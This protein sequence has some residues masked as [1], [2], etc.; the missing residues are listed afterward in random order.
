MRLASILLFTLMPLAALA[1]ERAALVIGMGDYENANDLDGPRAD[2]KAVGAALEEL[3]FDVTTLIDTPG[4]DLKQAISDFAFRA[5][6]AEIALVYYAGHRLAAGGQNFIIPAD[7]PLAPVTALREQAVALPSLMRAAGKARHMRIVVLDSCQAVP[8]QSVAPLTPPEPREGTLVLTSGRA[9]TCDSGAE[10]PGIFARTL[11]DAL[12][13]PDVEISVALD[14]LRADLRSRT[15]G[16]LAPRRFGQLKATP[17]FLAG[18]PEDE[19]QGPGNDRRRTWSRLNDAQA[20]ELAA[21][22]SQGDSR[23]L[24]ASAYLQLNPDDPRH[25]PAAAAESLERAARS[26]SAEA[27]YQLAQLYEKGQGVP[28]D[29][30]RALALYAEAAEEGYAPALNDLGFIHLQGELGQEADEERA[31]D[32]FRRAA[33]RRHPAAMFNYAALIDDG[34]V[35]G[36]G[37]PDA[38]LYLYRALRGGDATLLDLMTDESELFNSETRKALQRKL[39]SEGFYDGPIDGDYGP[40]TQAGIREAYTGGGA[41]EPEAD[42]T[43]VSELTVDNGETVANEEEGEVVEAASDSTAEAA[44]EE[45]SEETEETPQTAAESFTPDATP[46]PGA[47]RDVTPVLR[48]Q[49]AARD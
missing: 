31:R 37:A 16:E 12:S 25:D 6:T 21:L 14:R 40:G 35:E 18:G 13:Q 28:K 43:E 34:K 41:V 42:G 48:P 45:T 11:I 27:R 47:D 49:Q 22:A 8:L 24:L 32:Y 5:E 3:D 20:S 15:G 39:A 17:Y 19:D 26:G 23:A 38:A 10:G 4:A 33:D 30:D 9:G 29:K 46:E 2:A 36:R 1:Q 7:G 44:S